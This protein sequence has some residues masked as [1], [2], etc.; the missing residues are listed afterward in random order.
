MVELTYFFFVLDRNNH[1]WELGCGATLKPVS[2]GTTVYDITTVAGCLDICDADK[3]CG[4]FSFDRLA[5]A[6]T[7][8]P[9]GTGSE[10]IDNIHGAYGF[11]V[12]PCEG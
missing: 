6:C 1:R 9:L 2:G 8:Y 4:L 12:G 7:M 10:A 5:S 11:V 3:S